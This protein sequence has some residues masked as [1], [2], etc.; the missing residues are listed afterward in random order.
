MSA[1]FWRF[2]VGPLATATMAGSLWLLDRLGVAIPAP[3]LPNA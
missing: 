1:A 2:M 3:G